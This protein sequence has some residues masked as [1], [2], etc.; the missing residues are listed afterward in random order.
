MND[1]NNIGEYLH[2]E[3]P[4][5][6]AP[7]DYWG[8]VCRTVKGVPVRQDQI[9]LIVNAIKNGLDINEKDVI[10]DIGCGNGALSQYFFEDCL[11]YHGVDFS[12]YLIDVAKKNFENKPAHTFELIDAIKYVDVCKNPE[13]YNNIIAKN[14][15]LRIF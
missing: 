1:K 4:K 9:D 7:D 11:A 13:I 2:K 5:S 14:F 8:Q 15:L 6:C 3:Y 10:L 12:E